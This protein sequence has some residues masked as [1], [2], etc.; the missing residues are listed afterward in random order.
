M[1]AKGLGPVTGLLVLWVGCAG[2]ERAPFAS[3]GPQRDHD[4]GADGGSGPI[5]RGQVVGPSMEE[6]LA[7]LEQWG[8]GID[9]PD[10]LCN[11]RLFT[12]GI[13]KQG[14]A[15]CWGET[16]YSPPANLPPLVQ[17]S[18]REHH[19][20]ALGEDGSIACWG[21][22]T[23]E[24]LIGMGDDR[25]QGQSIV[26]P[27][28]YKEVSAGGVHTCAINSADELVCWGAGSIG[29]REQFPNRNQATP[30][31]GRFRGVSA[32]ELHTC[33]IAAT[34]GE[35]VCWGAGGGGMGCLPPGYDCDQ[36]RVPAGSVVQVAA[37][38]FHSCALR[39]NGSVT[40]WGYG[41]T[42][43]SCE[44]GS[45]FNDF[46]CGQV[47]VPSDVEDPFARLALGWVFSCALTTEFEP[48]CWGWELHGVTRV[49]RRTFSQLAS[50]GD[51]YTCGI[52]VSG[53]VTC[54][55]ESQVPGARVPD[56]FPGDFAE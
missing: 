21:P 29:R 22:G 51:Q 47:I 17:I 33:A 16:E 20:C 12:C 53:D 8:A 31:G 52:E 25:E 30:P 34:T 40:C 6:Q 3:S 15:Q 37:G 5:D 45:G 7:A 1:F 49:P 2:E 19:A 56:T 28:S 24:A 9:D 18:C 54:W 38:E 48:H 13:D 46:D 23:D 55:G 50:G 26:P 41:Q 43:L 4:A 35:A 44:D 14:R 36:D 32:G 10:K 11:A 42:G 39:D 27:G